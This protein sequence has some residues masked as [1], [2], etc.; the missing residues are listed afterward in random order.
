MTEKRTYPRF[1]SK[2]KCTFDYY[3]GDPE[4]IDMELE[5]PEQGKGYVMDISKGGV[6]II[7]DERVAV[8]MPVKVSFSI[9]KARFNPRGVIVRTGLLENNPSEIARRFSR[10]SA[11]GE[12]YIAVEFSEPLE[13]FD[14]NKL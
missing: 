3:E 13:D 12:T 1:E 7:S 9:G 10:Y 2:I 6:F 11:K 14:T 8:S 4:T 5:H